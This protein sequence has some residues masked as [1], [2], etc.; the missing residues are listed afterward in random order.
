MVGAAPG[1]GKAALDHIHAAHS[2]SLFRA[3]SAGPVARVLH[4]RMV[5]AQEVIIQGQDDAGLLE[6]QERSDWPAK[7]HDRALAHVVSRD[8][9]EP[10]PLCLG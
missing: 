5:R 4:M 6:L 7:C 10:H 3:A 8:G 1:D 9:V 2:L